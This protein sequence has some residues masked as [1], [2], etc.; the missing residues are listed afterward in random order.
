M[1]YEKYVTFLLRNQKVAT[2]AGQLT[3]KGCPKATS[4]APIKT[5]KYPLLTSVNRKMPTQYSPLPI[6][7]L[8]LKPMESMMKLAGKLLKE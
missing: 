6:K 3:M 2:F 5:K 1:G 4:M 7:K 8:T